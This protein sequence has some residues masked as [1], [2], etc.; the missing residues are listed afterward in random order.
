MKQNKGFTLAELLIVVAVIA[1]LVAVA[2]PTFGSQLEKSR[3]STDQ[4]NL[5]SAYAAAKL[6]ILNQEDANSPLKTV[7]KTDGVSDYA[8]WCDVN[9]GTFTATDASDDFNAATTAATAGKSQTGNLINTPALPKEITYES[10][11]PLPASEKGIVVSFHYNWD[12][13]VWT[14]SD[15]TFKANGAPTKGFAVTEKTVTKPV[16]ENGGKV[17]ATLSELV[18]VQYGDDDITTNANTKYAVADI[19][20]ADS[21]DSTKTATMAAVSNKAGGDSFD[22]DLANNYRGSIPVVITVTYTDDD[23]DRELS[24]TVTATINVTTA[25]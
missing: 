21:G 18:A 14:L 5:R 10:G 13:L 25:T 9:N 8:F 12:T 7:S 6:A 4:A 19:S 22:I 1:V 17:S 16:V 3:Q 11:R 23:D 20:V 15:I 2:I 24:S